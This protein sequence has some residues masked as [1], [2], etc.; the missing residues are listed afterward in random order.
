MDDKI[1]NRVYKDSF[2]QV[3]K[4]EVTLVL[5]ILEEQLQVLHPAAN[6]SSSS[7]IPLPVSCLRQ[8][9]NKPIR[10]ELLTSLGCGAQDAI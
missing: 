5:F 7:L 4:G 6:K 1:I 2:H 9:T 10:M 3:F 8:L